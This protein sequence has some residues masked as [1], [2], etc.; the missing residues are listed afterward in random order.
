PGAPAAKA[1]MTAG[2]LIISVAGQPTPTL[3]ALTSML[4]ELKPG[5]VV[6]VTVLRQDRTKVTLHVTL[7]SY[8]GTG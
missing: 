7:G 5:E 8:P 4:A 1:G 2:E 6:A 3:D